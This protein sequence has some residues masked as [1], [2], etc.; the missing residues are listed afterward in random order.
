MEEADEVPSAELD[1]QRS[2][3]PDKEVKP[4]SGSSQQKGQKHAIAR[5]F[6]CGRD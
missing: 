1:L 5:L 2:L 3:G 4:P 6:V